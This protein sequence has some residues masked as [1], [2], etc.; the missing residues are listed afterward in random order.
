MNARLPIPRTT[1]STLRTDYRGLALAAAILVSALALVA[2]ADAT[3][4]LPQEGAPDELGFSIGGYGVGSRSIEVRGDTVVFSQVPWG[5]QDP[6]LTS[7]VV[8]TPDAWRAFWTA[9]DRAGVR[10][11]RPKYVAEGIVDGS[12]WG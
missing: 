6:I 7:R 11:W 1:L 8:P 10:Q 9:A 4:P 12:G 2:C 3:G 5:P